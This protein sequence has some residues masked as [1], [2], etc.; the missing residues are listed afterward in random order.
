MILKYNSQIVYM[1]V[2]IYITDI[3]KIGLSSLLYLLSDKK[4]LDSA[5]CITMIFLI[6]IK[7]IYLIKY[8][9]KNID[10]IPGIIIL[11]IYLVSNII[12][13]NN[14]SNLFQCIVISYIGIIFSNILYY[15]CYI[16]ESDG[17][18]GSEESDE[19]TVDTI[20]ICI[21]NIEYAAEN[22][23]YDVDN[24][25]ICVICL[26]NTQDNIVKFTCNHIYHKEC[27]KEWCYR[28]N[29]CPICKRELNIEMNREGTEIDNV[30]EI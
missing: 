13:L 21:N 15:S 20:T 11:F 22:N 19:D 2:C 3:I 17:S 1:S 16:E 27:I 28:D 26:E 10:D 24:N 9:S 4:E 18:D 12:N 6:F 30:I 8:D 25:W 14:Q 23:Q 5:V 29:H 7:Y